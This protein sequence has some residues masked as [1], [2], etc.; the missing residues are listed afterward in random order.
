RY[1]S[2]CLTHHV[3]AAVVRGQRLT[4]L[5]WS[6]EQKLHIKEEDA[7]PQRGRAGA[8]AAAAPWS[9]KRARLS[10]K[11]SG[12]LPEPAGETR[13]T[14][15]RRPLF[16]IS[17]RIWDRR[18]AAGS[19]PAEGSP[20]ASGLVPLMEKMIFI[21]NSLDSSVTQLHSKVDLLT[22]ELLRTQEQVPAG[23]W[24][25][26]F[27]PP[28]EYLLTREELKQLMEQT[29]SA[30]ELGCRLLLQLFPELFRA[31]A[32]CPR[33]PLGSLHLQLVR[34]YV[35]ACY[36]AVRSHHVWRD[37]CLLQLNRFFNGFRAQRDTLEPAL[38]LRAPEEPDHLS[39]PEDSAPLLLRRLFQEGPAPQ[40]GGT[41]Q[42]TL[43]SDEVKVIRRY[44]EA[45]FPAVPEENWLQVCG[46]QPEEAPGGPHSGEAHAPAAT[47]PRA[48]EPDSG[49]LLPPVDFAALEIPLPSFAVP[50]EQLLS[51]EQLRS[52][53]DCS[54]SAEDFAWRLLVL[55]F[56]EL[57]GRGGSAGER[58]LDPV[59]VELLRH[60]VQLVYPPARNQRVWT[61]ELLAPLNQRCRRRRCCVGGREVEPDLPSQL[62]G[63][64]M[65]GEVPA[66]TAEKSNRDVCKMA[67]EELSVSVPDFPVP[68]GVLLSSAEVREIVQQSL[69]VGNFAARLLV[70]LFPELFTQENLRLQYNHSG[71]CNKKQL[72]P[73]RLRLI[74]HYVESVFPAQKMEEV[75][76]YEC[77]P[78]IDERCR[79]PNRKKCDVL[80]KARRGAAAGP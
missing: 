63:F 71:A 53:Y 16:S 58:Q 19:P 46:R 62:D 17:H 51:R 60:Y 39:S 40:Q 25:C 47:G 9:N 37:Q 31:T 21:L 20:Q 6:S 54:C 5:S 57:R 48:S 64:E 49:P 69:S 18:S 55:L 29:S 59:R 42:P 11:M 76:H 70:R 41:G 1:A 50:Q 77:V 15:G 44:T 23:P 78:S 68:P 28:P 43:D 74:R 45:R 65:V 30:G 80:K 8:A 10:G 56:P 33:C 36:P 26:H 24:P 52:S 12:H 27:R 75:W 38:A 22:L 67:L 72:D 34:N 3:V 4:S 13:Q 61:S 14:S 73:L 7:E 79:R 66:V 35:E 2:S 32:R